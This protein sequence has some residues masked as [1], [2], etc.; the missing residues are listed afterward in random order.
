MSKIINYE[1][2]KICANEIIKCTDLEDIIANNNLQIKKNSLIPDE[3]REKITN[4]MH[5]LLK[6]N[7]S[8]HKSLFYRFYR[9]IFGDN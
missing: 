2:L 8:Y 6:F 3:H 5:D 1:N 4:F 7:F 9:M